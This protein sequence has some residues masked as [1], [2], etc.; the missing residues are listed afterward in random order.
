MSA[1]GLA[2]H[3][4]RGGSPL[5]ACLTCCLLLL[6]CSG[7]EYLGSNA[8][9]GGPGEGLFA[10]RHPPTRSDRFEAAVSSLRAQ[11][12]LLAAA[13]ATLDETAAH[14][15]VDRLADAIA[16][17]PDAGGV[18]VHDAAET[19]RNDYGEVV[20]GSD[21]GQLREALMVASSAATLLGRGPYQTESAVSRRAAAFESAAAAVNPNEAIQAQ[22]RAVVQ[23]LVAAGAAL[24]SIERASG[25]PPPPVVPAPAAP[26]TPLPPAGVAQS[27][28][29]G[30]HVS[31]YFTPF[32]AALSS[33]ADAVDRLSVAQPDAIAKALEGALDS[34]AD[35]MQ[36]VPGADAAVTAD[37]IVLMRKCASDMRAAP[38]QS[39]ART[40]FAKRVLH[41]AAEALS[42][43]AERNFAQVTSL[44]DEVA[45]MRRQVDVIDAQRSLVPQFLQVLGALEAAQ[46]ALRT[47]ALQPPR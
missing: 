17:V 31:P 15:A 19:M 27:Q 8:A 6:G 11:A 14:Q 30:L 43:V 2:A 32:A 40:A 44:A 26:G 34:L 45:A 47:I 28:P 24:A 10:P 20:I 37:Q 42:V 41:V 13:P 39:G 33:Y 38:A 7:V 4:L 12:Q 36:V 21:V 9:P 5:A 46:D 3:A 29:P 1:H 25:T 16:N 18:D 35:V 23:A 22:P